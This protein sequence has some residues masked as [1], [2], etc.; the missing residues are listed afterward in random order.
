MKIYANKE[1]KV[2]HRADKR[3]DACRQ[4]ILRRT[5]VQKFSAMSDA[6]S[7]GYRACKR[8]KPE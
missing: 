4:S 3:G 7:D 2:A 1:T 5:N 6:R 8:C